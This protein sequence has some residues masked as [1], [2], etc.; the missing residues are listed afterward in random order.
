MLFIEMDFNLP[1][2]FTSKL[3]DMHL[4]VPVGV[5]SVE[6]ERCKAPVI[7]V[8]SAGGS[9]KFHTFLSKIKD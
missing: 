7:N 1:H 3:Q 9:P 8:Y 2:L 6:S 4:Q 5:S